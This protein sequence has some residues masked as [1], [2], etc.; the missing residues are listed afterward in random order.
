MI[1]VLGRACLLAS[2]ICGTSFAIASPVVVVFQLPDYPLPGQ[3]FSFP[4][5]VL[6]SVCSNGR[7]YR[8][9][10]STSVG[11]E[12]VIGSIANEVVAELRAALLSLRAECEAHPAGFDQPSWRIEAMSGQ[13]IDVFECSLFPKGAALSRFESM[14]WGTELKGATSASSAVCE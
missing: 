7:A 2:S 4:G 1:N 3:A 9:L 11:S 5:G 10:S 13:T 14:V 12:G 6:F 8:A